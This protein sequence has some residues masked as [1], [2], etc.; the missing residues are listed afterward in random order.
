MSGVN[1]C[2]HGVNLE[3]DH[4]MQGQCEDIMIKGVPGK[5][6]YKPKQSGEYIEEIRLLKEKI[7]LLEVPDYM[8]NGPWCDDMKKIDDALNDL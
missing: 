4:C 7:K 8:I 5:G 2:I 6:I 3:I 1:L